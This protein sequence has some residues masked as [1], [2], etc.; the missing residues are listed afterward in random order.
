MVAG[1]IAAGSTG[2]S[3]DALWRGHVR[4]LLGA[5]AQAFELPDVTALVSLV[6]FDAD[7]A[8]DATASFARRA[9]KELWLLRSDI[10][11]VAHHSGISAK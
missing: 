6:R 9:G 5:A 11:H 3:V 4:G 1:S 8:R 2:C 7:E 10:Q